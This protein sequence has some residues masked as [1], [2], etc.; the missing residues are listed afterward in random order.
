MT[1]VSEIIEVIKMWE[2]SMNMNTKYQ[3][4]VGD[5]MN[6]NTKYH[7]PVNLGNIFHIT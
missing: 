7:V 1:A 3:G 5:D 2:T 4:D 6:M